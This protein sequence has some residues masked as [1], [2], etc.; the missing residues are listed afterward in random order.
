MIDFAI[1]LDHVW[2]EYPLRKDRPGFKEFMVNLHRFMK[3]TQRTPRHFYA[4]KDLTLQVERGDCVGV[5][6]RN[7]AGKS[8][9][10]SVVL[11]TIFPAK[12]K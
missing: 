3:K 4:L 1:D 6:G 9:L 5:I 10:L 11:G 12:G 2:K 8:T 7:G